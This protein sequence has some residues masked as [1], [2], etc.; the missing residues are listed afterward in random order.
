MSD[1]GR[2]TPD[3]LDEDDVTLLRLLSSGQ[4]TAGVATRLD[5]SERTVR[6]RMRG[7]CDELGVRS[8]M[9]AVVLAVRHR[10]I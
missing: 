10:V 7:I 6:R 2:R 3:E 9:E 8:S 5:C 1:T 4:T